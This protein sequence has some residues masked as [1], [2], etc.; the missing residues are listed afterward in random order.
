MQRLYNNV[1]KCYGKSAKKKRKRNEG[2]IESV[3]MIKYCGGDQM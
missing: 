3:E 2:T 1:K